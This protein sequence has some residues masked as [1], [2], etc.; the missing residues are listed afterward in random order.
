MVYKS[1]G[2]NLTCPK[3]YPLIFWIIIIYLNEGMN[4]AMLIKE[5]NTQKVKTSAFPR[6]YSSLSSS[7]ANQVNQ[8]NKLFNTTVLNTRPK[9]VK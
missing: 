7:P 8:D 9:T 1:S 5:N 2:S 4:S 3:A 6:L